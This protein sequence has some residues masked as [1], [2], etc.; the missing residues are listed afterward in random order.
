MPHESPDTPIHWLS[1][2]ITPP[3]NP[4]AFRHAVA[5]IPFGILLESIAQNRTFGR[6]SIY[7]WDAADVWPSPEAIEANP[8]EAL[9]RQCRPWARFVGPRS[10]ASLPAPELP[11]VG[12]WIGYLSYECGRFVEPTAGWHADAPSRIPIAQ[13]MLADTV[14]IYDRLRDAW[15][16]AGVE[17]PERLRPSGRASL[18]ERLDAAEAFVADRGSQSCIQ[19]IDEP[20]LALRAGSDRRDVADGHWT[21]SRDEYFARVRRTLDYIRAGDI[22]QANLARGYRTSV[23]I[24]PFELYERLCRKNPAVY[25]AFLRIG[26]SD[27]DA[28]ILSSSPELFLSLRGRR[29]MT[30]PI[31]GTR[32]RGRDEAEDCLAENELVA[33]EKDRAELNMIIDLERNDLG[34]VCEFGSVR[35]LDE[36]CIETHPT[37][38]HRTASI[39][40][41]LRPDADAIDLLSATFPGGSITGAPK[42]R[43]MQIIQELEQLPRGPYCGA[44]GYI[45]LDGDMQLNLAIRTLT[46]T[47]GVAEFFVGS[48]I[49]ADSVPEEEYAELEAKAAGM[50]AALST[51]LDREVLLRSPPECEALLRPPHPGPRSSASLPAP[52]GDA[53]SL[54]PRAGSM[55]SHHRNADATLNRTSPEW[56]AVE[57][58]HG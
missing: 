43:A 7:A 21:S 19:P 56:I 54:A 46:I 31:K 52:P 45:G 26:T 57:T 36:G 17:L 40:G 48:G 34:R 37:V 51:D 30:R 16:V 8:F 11:F 22:F 3:G 18:Y 4:T 24:S 14:V 49:V 28:A 47:D 32:P 23:N 9:R 41:L 35:V 50:L 15:H 58:P 38:L 2:T 53:P 33:S 29:V 10:S 39:T 42:V 20:S 12:G 13:W 6:F 44:I 1:R 55:D 5:R 25:A 27:D